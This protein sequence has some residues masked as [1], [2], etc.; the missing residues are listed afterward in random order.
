MRPNSPISW[1]TQKARRTTRASSLFA[2]GFS[3]KSRRR[4]P[5]DRILRAVQR[6]RESLNRSSC[7]FFAQF[8]TEN[9]CTLFLEL[10]QLKP[11]PRRTSRSPRQ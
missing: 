2:N 9:R 5:D 10:L 1:S 4:Q 6:L 3:T 8:R 11:P 7:L